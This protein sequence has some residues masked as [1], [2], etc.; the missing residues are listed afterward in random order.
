MSSPDGAP[1]G[2]P[3]TLGLGLVQAASGAIPVLTTATHNAVLR[4]VAAADC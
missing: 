3:G 4:L 2:W 1:F